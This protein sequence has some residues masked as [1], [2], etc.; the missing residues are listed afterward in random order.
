MDA[1][2]TYI[3]ILNDTLQKKKDVMV[4]IYEATGQQKILLQ[5][6]SLK[7]EEFQK[8]IDLKAV[9]LSELE[10]LDIGFEQIYEKVG[11]ALKYNKELYK[12]EILLAQKLIQEIM[13]LSVSIRAME[14][15]NKQRFPASVMERRKHFGTVKTNSRIA[16][17][18]YKNMPN[19]HK[20]GYS[21]FMDEKK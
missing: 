6:G 19:V 10:K 3:N 11:M 15:Q 1:M 8:I 5:S 2:Y 7:E 18:Y 9:L 4:Q 16:N 17:N 21:Y 14:E 20:V 13:D 12:E